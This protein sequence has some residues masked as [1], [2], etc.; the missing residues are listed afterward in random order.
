MTGSD[1]NPSWQNANNH[2]HSYISSAGFSS[3]GGP[4]ISTWGTLTAAN[5]YTAVLNIGDSNGGAWEIASKD[6]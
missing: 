5:N 3:S 6:N 2:T 1:G 4:T